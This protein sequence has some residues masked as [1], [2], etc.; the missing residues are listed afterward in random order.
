MI[1]G[2]VSTKTGNE[3]QKNNDSMAP[4]SGIELSP[5]KAEKVPGRKMIASKNM[6]TFGGRGAG[7]HVA[8]YEMLEQ[9]GNQYLHFSY[10]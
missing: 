2:A 5:R 8:L 7:L 3:A 1:H 9:I 4:G 10:E 6:A